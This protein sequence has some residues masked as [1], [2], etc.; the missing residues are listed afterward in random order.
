MGAG[1]LNKESIKGRDIIV[2]G[3]QPW[4]T[5][6]GSNCKNIAL[7]FSKNNRVLYVNSPLDRITLWRNKKDPKTSKRLAIIQGKE[8]GLIHIQQNIWNFYPD[9]MVESINWINNTKIFNFF[10]RFNNGKLARSIQKAIRELDFKD[11]ILFNDNEMFKGF[12]LNDFLKPAV[13]IYYSRDYM[14]AVD[15]WRKHGVKLEPELI[16]KNDLCVA[17]STFLAE[18]CGQF[19]PDSFDV[20]QGCD[21]DIFIENKQKEAP[22][23]VAAIQGTVIGYV[24]ALQSIRLDRDIIAHIA[25][26]RPEWTVVLVG[27]EDELFKI[28]N[29]HEFANVVFTGS[30]P[31]SELPD[32]IN[33]FDVCINPQLINEVTIGNYPRKIDE[34]LAIGKPVVATA[35]KAME[36]FSD[37]VYLA[38]DKEEYILLIEE[39]L[40]DN[41]VLKEQQRREFALGHTWEN[42]VAKIYDAVRQLHK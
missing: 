37:F 21:L 28:S 2:V 8:E 3:Q 22:L 23:D 25:S 18:Y 9:C 11:F 14:V 7:E 34:Y 42:S 1:K 39:A 15:Y 4:D 38:K 35:T 26:S 12:F 40:R 29:L 5:E 6:I 17:N 16:A 19:N 32:Y 10:N 27:P 13:S 31:I 24:G 36:T 20:G 33:F 41:S 30:K